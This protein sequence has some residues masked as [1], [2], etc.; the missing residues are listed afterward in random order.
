MGIGS[1]LDQKLTTITG[2]RRKAYCMAPAALPPGPQGNYL[3]GNLLDY[4]RDPLDFMVRCSRE[5]GGRHNFFRGGPLAVYDAETRQAIAAL[6]GRIDTD[7]ATAAWEAALAA[8]WQGPPV[9]FHGDVAS[10]NLLVEGGRLSAVIDF[11]TSGVGDPS[12]DLAIAWTLFGGESREAFRAV[13]RPEDATWA[14]GRGWVIWK[15]L[16]TLAKHIDTDLSE[17][18]HARCVINGVLA[19]HKHA[20]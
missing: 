14:R 13:L 15:A 9:W 7:P 17:A 8:T 12:C 10:G 5:Y 11:G 1:I 3:I 2:V 18:G 19:D 20:P 6:K 4:A 16:I